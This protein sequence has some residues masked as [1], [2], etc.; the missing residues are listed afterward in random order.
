MGLS[1]YFYMLLVGIML[2]G[3]YWGSLTHIEIATHAKGKVVPT[4]KIRT[5]QNLEGG[6]VRT[7]NVKEGERIDAGK[8]LLEF[9]AVASQSEVNELESH[10]AFLSIE[11]LLIKATLENRLV[12]FPKNL[13]INHSDLIVAGNDQFRA[14][15]NVLQSKISLLKNEA[16]RG[17][18]LLKSKKALIKEKKEALNLVQNQINISEGL[19][20]EEL[21]SEL[22]H[23]D[24][25]RAKKKL[26]IEITEAK[27]SM[28]DLE[29]EIVAFDLKIQSERDIFTEE[30]T[31][32]YQKYNDEKHK[33]EKRLS[34]FKDE[35][36]RRVVVSPIDGIVK[37]VWVHTI[38]GVVQ[39]GMDLVEVVPSNETLVVE[40]EL[41]VSDVGLVQLNQKA[42]VRLAGAISV[43]YDAITGVVDRISPDTMKNKDS[44][45]F[46]QVK[47]LLDTDRFDGGAGSF[48]LRPG[49]TVD[50]SL[51]ISN[52][53]LLENL[54]A[55]FMSAKT[56]AFSENVWNSSIAQEKWG[57]KFI[58]LLKSSFHR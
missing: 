18:I 10:I 32:R 34:R 25:L 28:N 51:I 33:Y 3:V 58:D 14:R 43:E 12:K 22:S 37:K 46:Y 48:A 7:I 24:L 20:A 13:Q 53:S 50:C 52:R 49:L 2:A 30:L 36:G 26:E 35:L 45:E 8:T 15:N 4:G 17:N 55:P 42:K 40:A 9:E 1:R 5:I 41:P 19:L 23:L 29:S 39:P 31:K 44:E 11:L 21:T 54:L 6:I 16:K 38:G 47:I 56:K 57:L 27:Q